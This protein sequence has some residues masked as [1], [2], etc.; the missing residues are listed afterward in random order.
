MPSGEDLQLPAASLLTDEAND[1]CKLLA[2]DPA[3][4]LPRE[5][6]EFKQPK[7]QPSKQRLQLRY[8]YYEEKRMLKI[9]AIENILLKCQASRNGQP[10]PEA[11]R[12]LALLDDIRTAPG[13]KGASHLGLRGGPESPLA[14]KK[15][16]KFFDKTPH[17]PG[18][19]KPFIGGAR[20]LCNSGANYNRLAVA[21][22]T[23]KAQR[24]MD[25][26]PRNLQASEGQSALKSAMDDAFIRELPKS[27][28]AGFPGPASASAGKGARGI[29]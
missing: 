19:R 1:V 4:I 18:G 21:V 20:Q 28:L 16:W 15:D 6:N 5:Q 25:R 26:L 22:P 14:S 8:E 10:T 2:I 23:I 17:S 29:S 12:V 13:R 9:K 3:D 27:S 24:V 11:E 7:E